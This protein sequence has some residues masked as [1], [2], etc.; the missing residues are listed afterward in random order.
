M[1]C[2]IPRVQTFLKKLLFY[3]TKNLRYPKKLLY[4]KYNNNSFLKN[5]NLKKMSLDLP[6]FHQ[7]KRKFSLLCLLIKF[8]ITVLILVPKVRNNSVSCQIVFECE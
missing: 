5:T 1:Y 8:A 4:F 2:I 6:L 3:F 7:G